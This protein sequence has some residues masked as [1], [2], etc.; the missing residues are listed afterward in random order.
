MVRLD[1]AATSVLVAGSIVGA[2]AKV[3]GSTPKACELF[4]SVSSTEWLL[5]NAL[6]AFPCPSADPTTWSLEDAK[7]WL[8]AHSIKLPSGATQEQAIA[9]VQDNFDSV[10]KVRGIFTRGT[11]SSSH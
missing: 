9:L 6:T 8:Q 3:F 2:N 11:K 1:I 7:S 5:F 10:A 4:F